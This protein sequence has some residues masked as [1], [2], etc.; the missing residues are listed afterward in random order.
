MPT[1]TVIRFEKGKGFA[2]I[3]PDDGGPDVFVHMTDIMAFGLKKFRQGMRVR[4]ELMDY[5]GRI[6][7]TG[8]QRLKEGE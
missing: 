1:G 3:Q 2:F 7:A 4:Y 5:R 8:L 6:N